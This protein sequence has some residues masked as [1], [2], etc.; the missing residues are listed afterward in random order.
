MPGPIATDPAWRGRP[1]HEAVLYELHLGTFT[2]EGTLAAAAAKPPCL[3]ELGITA[4]E[5]MLPA[6]PSAVSARLGL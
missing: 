2:P 5:L 3:A 6:P 1:W 4:V